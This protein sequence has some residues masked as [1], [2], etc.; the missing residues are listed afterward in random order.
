VVPA[1]GGPLDRA[2]GGRGAAVRPPSY[3]PTPLRVR[4]PIP[5]L[6]RVA[7]PNEEVT[8]LVAGVLAAAPDLTRRVSRPEDFAPPPE[9]DAP[10]ELGAR[11][12]A[13]ALVVVR[14]SVPL[15]GL[16]VP[17]VTNPLPSYPVAL[18]RAGVDGAVVVEFRIDSAGVVDLGSLRV[19]ES[20]NGL[21]SQAV[22][23]VLPDLRF[24][25]AQ[26]R[27]RAVGVTVRQPF[28]FRM[29]AGR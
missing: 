27:E 2:S 26:L 17:L 1:R 10:A 21:F 20:T 4:L 11:A 6:P 24:F 19:V 3:R 12:G 23:R 28:V 18:E 9:W 15:A 25:P 5:A 16:P 22:R 13:R 14:Q 29:H 8:L 7:L